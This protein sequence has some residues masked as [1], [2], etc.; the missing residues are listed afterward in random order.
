MILYTFLYTHYC[1]YAIMS[2][3]LVLA[4]YHPLFVRYNHS[5]TNVKMKTNYTNVSVKNN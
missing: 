5:N 2:E 1:A 3:W 4:N